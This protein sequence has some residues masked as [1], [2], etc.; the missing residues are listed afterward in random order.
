MDI[1][2]IGQ[3]SDRLRDMLVGGFRWE[4]GDGKRVGFWRE[5]WIGSKPLWDVCPRLFELAVNKD[6]KIQE[7]GGWE[8]GRWRWS[9]EWRRPRLGRELSE[10]EVLSNLLGNVRLCEGREDR[11]KWKYDGNGIYVVKNAYAFLGPKRN[12][13]DEQE[14]KLIWCKFVPSKVNFFGW[15]LCLDRLATKGNLQRRGILLQG[16]GMLCGLCR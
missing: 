1:L 4:V 8:G 7:M 10:E 15:R 9:L 14:C 3:R 6:G 11:W 13:L 16:E 12:I 2:S 5:N